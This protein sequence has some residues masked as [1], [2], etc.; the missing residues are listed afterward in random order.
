MAIQ[1]GVVSTP[2]RRGP[3]A[4]RSPFRETS[5]TAASDRTQVVVFLT[6]ERVLWGSKT[7]RSQTVVTVARLCKRGGRH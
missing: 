4:V 7:L 1:R 5:Q 2:A 6:G 3:R